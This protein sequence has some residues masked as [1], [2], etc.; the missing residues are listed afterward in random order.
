MQILIF[1][2]L[3]PKFML[4]N[5]RTMK[6]YGS[7]HVSIERITIRVG[8]GHSDIPHQLANG[9]HTTFAIANALISVY[10]LCKST[11]QKKGARVIC[12]IF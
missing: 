11:W 3:L 6:D 8:R 10:D 4:R 9:L 7:I 5:T 2:E 1:E 12:L